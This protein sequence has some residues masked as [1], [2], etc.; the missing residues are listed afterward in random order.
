MHAG[1]KNGQSSKRKNILLPER[2]RLWNTNGG[3]HFVRRRCTGIV[4]RFEWR[5]EGVNYGFIISDDDG[6][7]AL[8]TGATLKRCCGISLLTAGDQLTYIERDGPGGR[9]VVKIVERVTL[10]DDGGTY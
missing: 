1:S 3:I 5:R 8:I 7:R 4:V 10:I 2:E 9:E 6:A